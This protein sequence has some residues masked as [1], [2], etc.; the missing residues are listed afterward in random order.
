M[1]VIYLAGCFSDDEFY[2]LKA[3]N[4]ELLKLQLKRQK[5]TGKCDCHDKHRPN[6]K[7]AL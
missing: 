1:E 2:S 6:R 7:M 3:D 4:D 5:K